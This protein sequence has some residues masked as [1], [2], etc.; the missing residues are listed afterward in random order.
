MTGHLV[1]KEKT[2]TRR[3]RGRPASART[4]LE[5]R[6]LRRI[7]TSAATVARLAPPDGVRVHRPVDDDPTR[8]VEIAEGC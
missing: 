1:T 7:S 5:K 3:R 8:H 2:D 4:E 6:R